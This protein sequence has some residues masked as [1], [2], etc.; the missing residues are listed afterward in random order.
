MESPVTLRLIETTDAPA[1]QQ[2]ASDPK[3]SQTT[4][5]PYPYPEDGGLGFVARVI[6]GREAGRQ[7]AFA[8]QYEGQFAGVMTLNAVDTKA[9][10]AEL[11][12]WVAAPFWNKGLGTAA[13]G[14]AI[15]YAFAEL[16]LSAL[17]SA[18]LVSNPASARVL[19]KSGFTLIAT[20]INDG[21]FGAKFMGESMKRFR[22]R[23]SEWDQR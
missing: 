6:A 3:I 11:D 9:G 12:Y 23:R 13:A 16:G 7:Y 15:R 19:E 21:A 4:N 20:L 2:Y 1:V 10:T 18:C 22:L 8:I 14:E 17:H 5:V